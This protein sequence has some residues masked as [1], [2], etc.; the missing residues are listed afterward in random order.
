VEGLGAPVLHLPMLHLQLNLLDNFQKKVLLIFV[1]LLRKRRANWIF[2][3]KVSLLASTLVVKMQK[4][5]KN[6]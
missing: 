2:L 5:V 6:I 4:S 3:H 1:V